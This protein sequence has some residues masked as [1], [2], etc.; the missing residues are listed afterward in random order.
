MPG[1]PW[2]TDKRRTPLV[3][4]DSMAFTVLHV[5]TVHEYPGA[6]NTTHAPAPVSGLSNRERDLRNGPLTATNARLQFVDARAHVW[7]KKTRHRRDTDAWVPLWV[8]NNYPHEAQVAM[9]VSLY[10]APTS[11]AAINA[12]AAVRDYNLNPRLGKSS[13]RSFDRR[14]RARPHRHTQTTAPSSVSVAL[15]SFLTTSRCAPLA[16]RAGRGVA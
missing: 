4:G 9:A 1:Q 7:L 3:T 8:E 10:D 2:K 16:A 5:I 11:V 6:G 15:S 14:Q 12:M 13:E